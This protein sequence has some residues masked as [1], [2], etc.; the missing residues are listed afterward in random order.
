[1]SYVGTEMTSRFSKQN[2]LFTNITQC[3]RSNSQHNMHKQVSK[4]NF[5]VRNASTYNLPSRTLTQKTH[6]FPR[7][8][9]PRGDRSMMVSAQRCSLKWRSSVDFRCNAGFRLVRCDSDLRSFRWRSGQC[10]FRWSSGQRS[11]SKRADFRVQTKRLTGLNGSRAVNR[12]VDARWMLEGP[13]M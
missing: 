5:R 10:S 9:Y 12:V 2:I 8:R 4:S 6:K 11:Y 13:P 3:C 7:Q 1:M